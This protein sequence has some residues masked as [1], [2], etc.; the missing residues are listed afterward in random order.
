[1]GKGI[2]KF[3]IYLYGWT[4]QLSSQHRYEFHAVKTSTISLNSHEHHGCSFIDK[5]L[6]R[7]CVGEMPIAFEKKREK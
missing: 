2:N 1:M 4:I 6:S 7:Y 3:T 5:N